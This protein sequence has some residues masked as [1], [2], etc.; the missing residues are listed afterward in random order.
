MTKRLIVRGMLLGGA[1]LLP[2]E[3]LAADLGRRLY[4]AAVDLRQRDHLRAGWDFWH[5]H[6]P[7]RTL[8]RLHRTGRRRVV[9]FQLIHP[10]RVELRGGPLLQ[11][12]RLGPQF[13]VRRQ[14]WNRPVLRRSGRSDQKLQGQ[15]IY[16]PNEQQ[17]GAERIVGVQSRRS[18]SLGPQRLLQC[19]LLYRKY[20]R[21][22]LYGERS[23]RLSQLSAGSLRRR[24][25]S[26]DVD[27]G[28]DRCRRRDASQ[29]RRRSDAG[30]AQLS[31]DPFQTGTRRDI[32]GFIGTYHWNDWTITGD[33][34]HEH[35]EGT[36][37]VPSMAD[38]PVKLSRCPSTTTPT[39]TI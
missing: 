16:E 38:T 37:E 6:R 31:R 19:D 12:L 26:N 17:F 21:L 13:S 4:P 11:F 1:C 27:A 30:S 9:R 20:H 33:L 10:R 22:N 5:E 34:R 36:V 39:F 24:N 23:D 7:I 29:R 32:V 28:G 2:L 14:P 18:G 25:Q 35:K 3:A 15:R 8:Q